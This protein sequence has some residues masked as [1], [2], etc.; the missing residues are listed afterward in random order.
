[1]ER[2][3]LDGSGRPRRV[4]LAAGFDPKDELPSDAEIAGAL[5]EIEA[6]FDR[7]RAAMGWREPPGRAERQLGELLD[8]YRPRQA[9]L[10]EALRADGELSEREAELV[11]A[12]LG[13]GGGTP[14]P[15]TEE[16][17]PEL[18]PAGGAGPSVGAVA[19]RGGGP[20]SVA[21]L[22]RVYRIETLRQ[23]G[24]VRA[25]RQISFDEYMALKRHFAR[26]GSAR[27]ES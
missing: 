13:Q 17:T 8:T 19:E 7:A 10:V 2:E 16:A 1:M 27:G 6:A 18:V 9:S 20:R 23:A 21:D 22:L 4:R 12:H 24:A 26:E 25:Q 14:P 3:L 5:A 11:L 15:P